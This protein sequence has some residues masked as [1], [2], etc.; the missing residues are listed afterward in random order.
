V[1]T[2]F[3]LMSIFVRDIARMR[4]FYTQHVGLDVVSQL[5]SDDFV[6]LSGAAGTPLALRSK[7]G[8][9]PI[10]STTENTLELA[11]D[12][13]DVEA[14]RQAWQEAGIDILSEI[15]DVGAGR[16][17]LAHDPE[18]NLLSISQLNEEVRAFRHQMG[19]GM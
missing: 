1:K 14:T 9:P 3:T 12:V 10:A 16:A 2:Y 4:D 5:S 15:T 6:F 7:E 17:F 8:L 11:F 19:M 18:G 13:E